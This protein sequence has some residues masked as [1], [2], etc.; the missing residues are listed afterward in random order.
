V[1]VVL[2]DEDGNIVATTTTD[3]NGDFSFTGLP[4]GTY[5]VDVT[6]AGNILNGLWHSDGPND[7]QNNNSQTDPYTVT[8]SGGVTNDT[9][10]FGYYGAPAS[11]GDFVWNDLNGDGIQNVGEPG[12][13]GV[14]VTLTIV[15]P[16]GDTATVTAVTDADGYYSFGNLLLD[17]SFNASGGAG[18]PTYTIL[19]ATPNGYI[20]TQVDQGFND[21]IDSDNHAGVVAIVV[22]GQVNN[23]YDFGFVMMVPDVT[24]IITAV[25]NV[26][27]GIT[28]Y[29]ITVRV[30]EL[31]NAPTVGLITVRI[32]KDVRWIRSEP[33]DPTLTVL[34]IIPVNNADWTYSENDTHHIFQTTK[35]IPAGG[36]STFGIKALWNAGPTQGQY[37]ITAQI[38][39]WSGGENRIDNNSDAEK[40]DYFI[41]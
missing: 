34:G 1:T 3:A 13:P 15:Y 39:S 27:T 16:N 23:T 28:P 14:L 2:R 26:M 35:T 4:D 24:P 37:T 8:V 17:E 36:F 25:P 6:D 20:P 30:I 29:N 5:T 33:Y 40:L 11:L 9:A 10:D 12:I 38:D 32:P 31:N 41:N 18:Q 21:A 19:V 7:G 22:Q